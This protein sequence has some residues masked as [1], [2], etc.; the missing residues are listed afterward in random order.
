M[1]EEYEKTIRGLQK[2]E[3]ELAS[4]MERVKHDNDKLA[5]KVKDMS[6][7][8]RSLENDLSAKDKEIKQGFDEQRQL[9]ELIRIEKDKY[10]HLEIQC[11][12]LKMEYDLLEKDKNNEISR[13]NKQ[14]VA[15]E[16][17]GKNEKEMAYA[18]RKL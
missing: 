6:E 3:Q 16:G 2:N 1:H 8:I 15:R 4:E 18:M 12:S 5:Q 13:M 10:L 17:S 9:H 14:L 11:K 7:K